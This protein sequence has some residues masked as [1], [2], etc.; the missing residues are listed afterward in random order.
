MNILDDSIIISYS[1]PRYD[2]LTQIFKQSLLEIGVKKEN[3]IHKLD[4]INES[5][6]YDFG[7][8]TPIWYY[9][10]L[11]K[12]KHIVNVLEN[13]SYYEN[14]KFI[15][16]SD[17][18]IWFIEKN[19]KEWKTLHSYIINNSKDI[20]F[21]REFVYSQINS[22]F[23]IIKNNHN[24]N[25]IIIF[26]QEV[27]NIMLNGRDKINECED[28]EVINKNLHKINW[29]YIPIEYGCW[30]EY[31]FNSSKALFHHAVCV[32]DVCHKIDQINEI[33]KIFS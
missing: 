4:I 13:K 6:A 26:F 10:I 33:K 3:I 29:G 25:A 5:I 23:F 17:C 1:T 31:V 20:F 32:K 14:K 9:C 2:P 30:G 21:L 11:Q 12:I 27:Y 19:L 18:D 7:F 15:I 24:I 22:G 8:R 28:Q 16:F